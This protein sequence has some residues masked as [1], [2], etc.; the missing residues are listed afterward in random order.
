M[1]HVLTI[2]GFLIALVAGWRALYG[3]YRSFAVWNK[4]R[5]IASIK[6]EIAFILKLHDSDRCFYIFSIQ[7]GFIISAIVSVFLLFSAIDESGQD[8][9]INVAVRVLV[10][11]IGYGV[12]L[13]AGGTVSRVK[14]AE[15]VLARLREK[16]EKI[17]AKVQTSRAPLTD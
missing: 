9:K 4:K 16:L 10:G 8:H 1:D 6:K 17:E 15:K 3:E 2:L 5:A 12:S 11:F 14:N 7:Y 13:Y